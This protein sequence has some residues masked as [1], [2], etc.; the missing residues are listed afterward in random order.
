MSAKQAKR[1]RQRLRAQGI[2]P[3]LDRKRREER[4]IIEDQRAREEARAKYKREHPEEYEAA[5]RAKMQ[6]GRRSLLHIAG[7]IGMMGR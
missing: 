5:E 4:E 3:E 2:E 1:E 7:A 6:R